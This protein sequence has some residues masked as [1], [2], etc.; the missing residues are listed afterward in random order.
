MLD[1]LISGAGALTDLGDRFARLFSRRGGQD[2]LGRRP[3]SVVAAVLAVIAGILVL[4]G[5]EASG[6]PNPVALAPGT[7]ATSGD[8]GRRVFV[9]VSGV[10][11]DAYVETY[12]DENGNGAKDPGEDASS[13]YYYLIDPATRSGVTVLSNRSPDE[14]YHVERQGRIVEDPTYLAEDMKSLGSDLK[15]LGVTMD[16]QRY[17]DARVTVP[18]P[19]RL[20]DLAKAPVEGTGVTLGGTRVSGFLW[21]CAKDVNKDGICTRDE[22]DFYDIVVMDPVTKRGLVVVQDVQP[23]LTPLTLT[24]ML[25]R[26]E[27]GVRDAK[28]AK[29]FDFSTLDITVS[30][31]YLLDEGATPTSAPLAFATAGLL[32]LLAA[33]MVIGLAGGYLIYRRSADRLPP[34][35]ITLGIGERIPVRVTGRVR[36]AG[37]EVHLREAPADLLRFPTSIPPTG[38]A[39]TPSPTSTAYVPTSTLIVER[40]GRPEGVALGR[41]ELHR[42]STGQVMP[43]RGSRPA[44]RVTAGTGP[45]FLSF[46]NAADRDRAAAELIGEAGL[47]V[48]GPS[49]SDTT[50]SAMT[51]AI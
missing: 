8:L 28:V 43:L 46:D 31:V 13:W 15:N 47:I 32:G 4:A 14:I 19:T 10:V 2:P 12:R 51:G 7:I 40:R 29:D 1:R 37:G 34:A 41:G 48:T 11:N 25:R 30:A 49:A 26:N 35:A 23:D 24:G 3:G 20:T 39:D 33:L 21:G 17:L 6:N 45:L 42:L 5:L 36:S 9:S 22:A 38:A 18:I 50:P 44:L 27:Q 16:E